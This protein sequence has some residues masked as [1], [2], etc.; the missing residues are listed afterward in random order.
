MWFL[1]I[2]NVESVTIYDATDQST[3]KLTPCR[4]CRRVTINPAVKC[5]WFV[6]VNY[7]GLW[8]NIDFWWNNKMSFWS[9]NSNGAFYS[10]I[11]FW[12]NWAFFTRMACRSRPSFNPACSNRPF[13]AFLTLYSLR[14]YRSSNTS[15][16]WSSHGT[17]RASW[18]SFAWGPLLSLVT[19]IPVSTWRTWRSCQANLVCSFANLMQLL[20]YFLANFLL[21]YCIRSWALSDIFSLSVAIMTDWSSLYFALEICTLNDSI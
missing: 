11:S 4:F 3:S 21:R 15:G 7:L 16:T 14:S 17:Q 18:A 8:K 9:T 13:V 12:A 5:Y 1:D 6:S 10:F 19:R 2:F 20:V